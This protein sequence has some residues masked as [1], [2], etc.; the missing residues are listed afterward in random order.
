ML[1]FLK[2]QIQLLAYFY[3]L[4]CRLVNLRFGLLRFSGFSEIDKNP[5]IRLRM[6]KIIPLRQIFKNNQLK[7][8]LNLFFD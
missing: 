8:G 4:E 2:N 3:V 7:H 1:S 5:A 6:L